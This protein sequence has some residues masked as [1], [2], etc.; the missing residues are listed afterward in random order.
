MID[1]LWRERLSLGDW[2]I[3]LRRGTAFALTCRLET[4]RRM[5]HALAR[6]LRGAVRG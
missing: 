1:H 5:F 2:L 4:A 6:Q 3:G